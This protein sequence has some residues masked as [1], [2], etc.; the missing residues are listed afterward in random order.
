LRYSSP[1]RTPKI[2]VTTSIKEGKTQLVVADNGLGIDLK[3]H[4]NKLFGL[5]KVF[6]RH[7]DSKGVGLYIVKNQVT[8]LKGTISCMS[9]VDKGSTFTITF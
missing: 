4:G 9:E 1:K 5:N 6:H 2:Q 7:K 8:S 3:K